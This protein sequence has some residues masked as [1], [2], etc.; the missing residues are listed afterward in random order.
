MDDSTAQQLFLVGLLQAPSSS[1]ASLVS[2]PSSP[3]YTTLAALL[4][5][6]EHQA[7]RHLLH[8]VVARLAQSRNAL[9]LP[10]LALY[11]HA[12]LPTNH[13]R[14]AAVI[15][16]AIAATPKL[17]QQL[18]ATLPEALRVALES[19]SGSESGAA[20]VCSLVRAVSTTGS[21]LTPQRIQDLVKTV[22]QN[23]PPRNGN[24]RLRLALLET[25]H[26]LVL[27]CATHLGVQVL[28]PV[29]ESLLLTHNKESTPDLLARDLA[30]LYPSLA[31]EL[32][33]LV[34]GA[35]G[36][37]ARSTKDLIARFRRSAAH[38]HPQGGDE[39]DWVARLRRTEEEEKQRT[40][41]KEEAGG[42][43]GPDS[44]S[45]RDSAAKD[46]GKAAAAA[47]PP[48]TAEREAELTK[49]VTSI[50]DLFPSES[51]AFLRACLLHPRFSSSS[52][53]TGQDLNIER[54]QEQVVEALLSD[55]S[56]SFPD[57]LTRIRLGLV[58]DGDGGGVAAGSAEADV[59]AVMITAAPSSVA[60]A[61]V[62]AAVIE[63]RNVYDDDKYFQR[64]KILLP[65]ARGSS[66]SAPA[67]RIRHRVVE[68]DERLK[69]S[70]LALA[71]RESSDD[72]EE[73]DQ[74]H[75]ES[76]EGG[77]V[78]RRRKTYGFLEEEEDGDDGTATPRIRIGGA[79]EEPDENEQEA[80]VGDG[81]G[82]GSGSGSRDR[83][84]AQSRATAPRASS[85][86]FT[87]GYDPA[88]VLVLESTYLRHP[89]VFARDAATRRGKARKELKERTGLGDEQIEGWKV[90]LERDPKKLQKMQDKHVDLGA[91]S[92]RPSAPTDDASASSSRAPRA[93][94]D[95]TAKPKAPGPNSGGGKGGGTKAGGSGQGPGQGQK[96]GTGSSGPKR[97][98]GG[99]REHDRAKRGRDR[100][101]ARMGAAGAPP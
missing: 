38:P 17:A 84:L 32:S 88:A 20:I 1:L 69:Q 24:D 4:A 79:D 33:Q 73:D 85:S 70:I 13:A 89:A 39:L 47:P 52:G 51:P 90:M 12:F 74:D 15:A 35:V 76:G 64:G 46:R 86:S 6:P 77:G 81:E 94:Q 31:E 34:L 60:E 80:E 37:V 55:G 62:P 7:N 66:D 97:S 26:D 54:A 75:L 95:G 16:D 96:T 5:H 72:E 59:A 27:S 41:N 92:N 48:L 8:A 49:A 3:V 18:A 98:D 71:E 43:G 50:L 22:T 65:S 56:S 36:P 67:A 63:R 9:P 29:L 21:V 45:W 28:Q 23:Y 78:A 42:G 11:A 91:R 30:S 99:R 68:L 57:E 25:V 14:V 101:L 93:T 53:S 10:L 44:S 19:G 82:G 2:L 61:P 40:H 83:P 58:D 87:A 100:K